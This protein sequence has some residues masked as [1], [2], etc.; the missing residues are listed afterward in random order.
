MPKFLFLILVL[1]AASTSFSQQLSKKLTNQDVIEMVSAGVSDHLIIEKIRASE[2]A[3]FD[4]SVA[5]LRALK[6][7]RVSDSVIEAMINPHPVASAVQGATVASSAA[8]VQGLP[9]EI[10]VYVLQKG[11]DSRAR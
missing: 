11:F 4:T 2:G 8:S 10:G 3:N 5:G 7:A 1:L 6:A 9:D